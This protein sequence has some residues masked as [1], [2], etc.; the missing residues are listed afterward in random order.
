MAGTLVE[1]DGSVMEGGGS[2]VR[3][4]SALSVMTGRPVRIRNIR[5]GRPQPGLRN[6][7]MRGLELVAGICNGR[8]EGVKLG[9]KD[10]TLYPG[11]I[12]DSDFSVTLDTAGSVG[13]VVQS[14]LM[15][16]LRAKEKITVTIE[17]GATFGK[18]APP[19][20]Y[21]Q[22]VLLPLLRRMGYHAEINILRHGFYPVGGSRVRLTVEPCGGLKGISLSERGDVTSL[23]VVS[24]ASAGLKKPRVAERQ[25]REA[26]T[27][28]RKRGY[29]PLTK[30]RYSESSC[31][32]SGMV[33]VAKTAG[34]CVLGA[35]GLGERSKSAEEVA[36]EAV[37]GIMSVLDSGA[38]VDQFMCDQLLPYMALSGEPCEMTAPAVSMHAAT[39]MHVLEKFLPVKFAVEQ[40][41]NLSRITCGS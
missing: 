36:A 30:K 17:G 4:S 28:L 13:L 24:V 7:H 41:G 32:G 6:Q 18:H 22:F 29:K 34:G 11:E 14:V 10:A 1:I 16:S 9:S 35:D 2:I 21:I 37:R 38:C 20:Q 23:D 5:S 27:M 12:T 8:L 31:N 40:S 39:N 19:L 15:A 3:L 26:E 25:A 33:M